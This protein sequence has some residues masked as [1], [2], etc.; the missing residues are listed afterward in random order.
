MSVEKRFW[1]NDLKDKS[2]QDV[3]DHWNKFYKFIEIEK[4]ESIQDSQRGL[5]CT[6]TDFNDSNGL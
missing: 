1:V 5:K 3:V 4:G 6:L 2:A